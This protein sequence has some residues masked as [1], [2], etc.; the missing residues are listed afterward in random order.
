MKINHIHLAFNYLTDL[1]LPKQKNQ[2][3][4]SITLIFSTLKINKVPKK[5]QSSH[6]QQPLNAKIQSIM[7]F[8]SYQSQELNKLIQLIIMTIHKQKVLQTR[9]HSL[10]NMFLIN[11]SQILDNYLQILKK[12]RS[13]K[14]KTQQI[15]RYIYKGSNKKLT[16]LF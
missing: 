3:L 10:I 5:G 4:F 13:V 2:I 14:F 6:S 9:C 1:I 12:V 11:L 15:S 16:P 7:E 8:R